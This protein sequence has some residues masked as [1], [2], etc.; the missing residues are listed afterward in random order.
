MT[1]QKSETSLPAELTG[2]LS[3][4]ALSYQRMLKENPCHP[5][6]LVGITLVALASRQ[7]E[8]AIQ[9]AVAAVA[10]APAMG[11]AWVALGQALKAV[12]RYEEAER[13]YR[14]GI[15]HGMDALGRMGLGELMLVTGRPEEGMREFDQA[16]C[17]QPAL[18]AAQI[19]MGNA[20]AMMGRNEEALARYEQALTFPPRLPEAEFAAG[21]VLARMGKRKEAEARYRRALVLRP[22]FAAAWMNLGNLLREQGREVYAEAA[23]RRAVE[24]RPDLVSGWVNLGVL[25]RERH[26]PAEAEAYLRKAFAINPEQVETLV[27]WCQFRSAERDLAGAW[28]WLRWALEREPGHAEAVNMHGIL[29][30]QEGRFSEAVEVFKQAE[31]L[32]SRAAT[33][34][35]G[36]SL[37]DLGF[38][39]EALQ[40]QELAVERDPGSFGARYNLSLTRL[41]LGRWEQGWPGYEARWRF[42]EVHR[43]PR[44]FPQPR[45]QGEELGGRRILLHAEQGLGDTIQF[46]R[47]ASM[48]AA[49]GGQ[50]ILQVQ[51][52]ALRLMQS[53]AVVHAGLA[54]TALLGSKP[55]EFDLECPLLSLPAVLGTTVETVPWPGAYLGATAEAVAGK[56]IQFP[57][58]RTEGEK[59][60]RAGLAWAGNPRYKADRLRS[61][62]LATLLPLLRTPGITW[63]TLQKGAAAEQ[64]ST[65][66][67]DVSVLDGSS[68]DC[69][70]AETA[71]LVSTLDLVIT[72]DTSI[73]HLAGAMGKP[74][75]ILLPHLSDWRWMQQIETTPWYP[76]ARLFRQR[77]PGDWAAV[78]E[79]VIGELSK[80]REVRS[81]FMQPGR[82]QRYSM[83]A[84][85][86]LPPV[87]A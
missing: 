52:P 84:S 40:A 17:R 43:A 15:L 13:A 77:A 57:A 32:G 14:R 1:M 75:W 62:K 56:W 33:S 30:H 6:A 29:L 8:R 4:V 20:L 51:E 35:R 87:P 79:R 71:A 74:V 83:Q 16:L 64:L 42:R 22:D 25:E 81:R 72:T 9:M 2:H 53:L 7:D 48:V 76:A 37:L 44:V 24:L 3:E 70:L 54:Q 31:A 21:F 80:L 67:N 85:Q 41:R 82:K 45:W 78:V 65:L 36:N 34:N 61:V 66:P 69:D 38:M 23:L 68:G 46:C 18:A 86:P 47:Y 63:I 73:A 5:E 12:G 28:R 55:P 39:D 50:V 19:G 10:A 59:T 11:A 27:T 58:V 60:L 49:R 26:R